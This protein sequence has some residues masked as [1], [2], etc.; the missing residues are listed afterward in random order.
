MIS[1]DLFV[2]ADFHHLTFNIGG[3][4]TAVVPGIS[5]RLDPKISVWSGERASWHFDGLTNG[6]HTTIVPI[7]FHIRS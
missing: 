7:T 4:F 3:G 1:N 2:H 5:N 6:R